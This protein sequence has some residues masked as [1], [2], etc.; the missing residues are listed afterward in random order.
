MR[1]RSLLFGAV[2]AASVALT[3]APA[4]AAGCSGFSAVLGFGGSLSGCWG[5]VI[6]A[7]LYKNAADVSQM[8][9]F[10]TTNFGVFPGLTGFAGAPNVTAAQLAAAKLN[11]ITDAPSNP[12][13]AYINSPT[14]VADAGG[15]TVAPAE[16]VFGLNNTTKNY[17]LWSGNVPSRNTWVPP[18]GIQNILLQ[19]TGPITLNGNPF[20]AGDPVY[21]LGWEDL[22]G[23]C[24]SSGISSM[25]P[26]N[27]IAW[28][29][30]APPGGN[31]VL[32]QDFTSCSPSGSS[33][34]DF[35]DF[36]VLID[37]RNPGN[38]TSITPEPMTMSLLA[39]GLVA[40]GGA[41][42]RRRKKNPIV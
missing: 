17:W 21:L 12:I 7:N 10:N 26:G 1:Y 4:S 9:A 5:D 37:V 40:M 16:L 30:I 20:G 18:N 11:G 8:Y 23:G 34:N 13:A 32:D 22:N 25:A 36:Y 15:N 33:D 31:A 6:V 38:N 29:S 41:S 19:V 24:L 28:S 42:I 39:V 2:A 27:Q 35:N 3:P 14:A